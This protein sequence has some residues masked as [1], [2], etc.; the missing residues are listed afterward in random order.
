MK[1]RKVIYSHKDRLDCPCCGGD[2]NIATTLTQNDIDN[3]LYMD[4]D[5][6]ICL[7]PQCYLD[8]GQITCDS[9]T[10]AQITGDW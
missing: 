2:V 10:L 4:G 7:D 6:V 3:N 1:I 8:N 5:E 9:E